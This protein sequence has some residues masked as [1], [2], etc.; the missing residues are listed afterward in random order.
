MKQ[1]DTE[2][3]GECNEMVVCNKIISMGIKTVIKEEIDFEM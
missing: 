2:T 1:K 3:I